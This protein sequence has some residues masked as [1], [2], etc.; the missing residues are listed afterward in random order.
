MITSKRSALR[1][2][3]FQVPV[4]YKTTYHDGEGSLMDIST[5]GCSV[6]IVTIPLQVED[7]VLISIGFL[8]IDQVIEA[9]GVVVRRS[10]TFFAVKFTLIEETTKLLIRK[11]FAQRKIVNK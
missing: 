3:C 8:D 7:V 2:T 5:S 10:E 9:K 1:F 4:K 6:D 11:V